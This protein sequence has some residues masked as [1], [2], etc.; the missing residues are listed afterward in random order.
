MST[1]K[2]YSKGCIE[3]CTEGGGLFNSFAGTFNCCNQDYCNDDI[4][5]N[6][7]I[8]EKINMMSVSSNSFSITV[9]DSI[10]LVCFLTLIFG[11]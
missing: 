5:L 10:I 3:K 4:S 9:S 11:F 7:K 6:A 2:S 8:N 1:I